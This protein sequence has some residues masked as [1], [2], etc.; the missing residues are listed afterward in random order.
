M[1]DTHDKK[2]AETLE[3]SRA[4]AKAVVQTA[5]EAAQRGAAAAEQAGSNGADMLRQGGNAAAQTAQRS[6]GAGAETMQHFSKLAEGATR[7]GAEL[8]ADGQQKFL[9][10]AA[11]RLEQTRHKMAEAAQGAAQ[12]LRTLMVLP[13]MVGGNL[14]DMQQGMSSFVEGV[15]Q[16]NL[17]AVH[18]LLR[19]TDPGTVVQLQQRFVHNYLDALIQGSAIMARSVRAT[20]DRTLRPLEEQIEQ[21]R[22]GNGRADGRQQNRQGGC[23]G[24]VMQRDVRVANPEDTVQHVARLMR[25]EDTGALPVGEDDQ[26]VGMVTDRDVTLRLVAEGRDPARTK[27]REVMTSEIR[28]VFEDEDLDA[29]AENMAEQQ[30]RRLPVLNRAKRMVGVVSLSDLAREGRRPH[31]AGRALGRIAKEGGR[32]TPQAAE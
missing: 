30:V 9:Q 23:I 5:S 32:Q 19:L 2:S 7:R 24:D 25:E 26:L 6:G 29:V 11:E 16:T 18:E 22:N 27:V 21:R 4:T 12:D 8:V 17:D 15:V 1:T 10:N 13:S 20:A 31:L 28:Y 3:Q 14:Q